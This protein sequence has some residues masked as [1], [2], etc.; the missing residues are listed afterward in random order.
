MTLTISTRQK[1]LVSTARM[2]DIDSAATPGKIKFYPSPRPASGDT[3][4]ASLIATM[5]FSDPCG[6]VDASGLHL[7]SAAPAQV[8]NG[9]VIRWCRVTDGDD[10]F[11]WDGDVRMS[12]DG[13]V[14][15]ADIVIDVANVLVGG[16]VTLVSATVA[17]G[18]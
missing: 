1:Q 13:D 3:T 6:T 7:T 4:A 12:T 15:I 8:I 16:F 17:E 18:G 11:V 14:A 2:A 10:N 5:L 9:G